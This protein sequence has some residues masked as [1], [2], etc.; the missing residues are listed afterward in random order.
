MNTKKGSRSVTQHITFEKKYEKK[1]KAMVSISSLD[2]GCAT[3]ENVIRVKVNAK[4][5]DISG[6]DIEINTWHASV[7]FEVKV[8]WISFSQDV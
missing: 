2:A 7:L 4:N 8:S 5:I 6:F 1:P 3:S